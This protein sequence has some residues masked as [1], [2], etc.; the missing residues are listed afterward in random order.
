[1]ITATI[2][3]ENVIVHSGYQK[4]YYEESQV[5]EDVLQHLLSYHMSCTYSKPE[6]ENTEAF[7]L[8]CKN[9]SISPKQELRKLLRERY[10][11]KYNCA[12]HQCKFKEQCSTF[13]AKSPVLAE[14]ELCVI[15]DTPVKPELCFYFKP[16][17]RM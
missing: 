3:I 4:Q 9:N 15:P 6:V 14:N 17:R 8:W 7:L 13:N 1:M 11:T 12:N 5:N 16:R 10:S 2:L